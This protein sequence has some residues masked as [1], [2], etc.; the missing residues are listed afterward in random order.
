[1]AFFLA[2]DRSTQ[3]QHPRHEHEPNPTPLPIQICLYI[4]F[5]KYAPDSEHFAF[6][7]RQKRGGL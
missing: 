1:M 5:C 4:G 7:N 3:E 6:L 2:D